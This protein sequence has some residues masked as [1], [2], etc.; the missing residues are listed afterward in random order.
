MKLLS[1]SS[2]I[3]FSMVAFEI[4]AQYFIQIA[5]NIN[6]FWYKNIY[7]YIGLICEILM[8]LLY[9]LLLK[10]G[11]SLAIANTII[12]GGGALG[13][14]LLGYL[15]FKQK[16]TMKQFIAILITLIGVILLGIFE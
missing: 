13:I 9:Y 3:I 10:S 7:L 1:Q 15:V 4:V 2:T 8:A 11:Y 5:V 6:T 14:V 12:D 16:I